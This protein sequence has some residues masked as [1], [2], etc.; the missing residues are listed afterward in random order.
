MGQ[1]ILADVGSR[2]TLHACKSAGLIGVRDQK[3][4][5]WLGLE[6]IVRQWPESKGQIPDGRAR[7]TDETQL[8]VHGSERCQGYA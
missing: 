5:P 3:G 6:L 1:Y 7:P 8:S 2:S 4:E